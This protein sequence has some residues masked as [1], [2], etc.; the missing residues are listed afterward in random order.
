M[1][2][3]TGSPE[4]SSLPA[5]SSKTQFVQTDFPRRRGISGKSI[6]SDLYR[7]VSPFIGSRLA[8][9][10]APAV[11][12]ARHAFSRFR[13]SFSGVYV[14][15]ILEKEWDWVEPS[16]AFETKVASIPQ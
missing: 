11:P 8:V 15:R 6:I 5:F 4:L 13:R 12:G 10:E 1:E 3:P 9:L 14:P 16:I 2:N 7:T